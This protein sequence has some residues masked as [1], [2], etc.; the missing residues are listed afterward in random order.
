MLYNFMQ[1]Q[2]QLILQAESPSYDYKQV[3]ANIF[4][5]SKDSRNRRLSF[6]KTKIVQERW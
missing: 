2:L 3:N 4:V 6:R 5:F 1:V